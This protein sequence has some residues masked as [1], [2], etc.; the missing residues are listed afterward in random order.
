MPEVRE[1]WLARVEEEEEEEEGTNRTA[2][3][4]RAISFYAAETY[5]LAPPFSMILPFR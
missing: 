4:E 1:R 5:A 3:M 2:E